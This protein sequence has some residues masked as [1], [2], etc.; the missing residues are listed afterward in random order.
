MHDELLK[1]KSEAAAA[2]AQAGDPLALEAWR[3][4]YLGR[5]GARWARR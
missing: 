1:L 3:V 4:K 2:L 5:K